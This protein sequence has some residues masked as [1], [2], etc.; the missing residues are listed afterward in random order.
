MEEIAIAQE[1]K[2]GSPGNERKSFKSLLES[3]LMKLLCTQRILRQFIASTARRYS[4]QSVVAT[5]TT[6][7]EKEQ[8]KI[9]K[10]KLSRQKNIC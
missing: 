9:L 2:F 3:L 8:R 1:S 6:T 4:H 10:E 7:T 5:K